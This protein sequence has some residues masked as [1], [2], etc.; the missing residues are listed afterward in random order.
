MQVDPPSHLAAPSR[1]LWRKLTATYEFESHEL[2]VL[3]L[4]LEALDRAA[5]ARRALKRHGTTYNDRFGAP[6][7]RPEVK[8]ERD[9]ANAAA[10][11]LAQLAIPV[12]DVE[13][14][15]AVRDLRRVS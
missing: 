10:R 1:A 2:E 6:H 8:I 13:S 9:S 12:E 14:P 15:G 4:A 7:A 11:F 5:T 3:R